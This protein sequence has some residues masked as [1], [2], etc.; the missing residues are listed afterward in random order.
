MQ[1]GSGTVAH[2]YMEPKT[3]HVLGGLSHF[4]QI[5]IETTEL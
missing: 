4:I 1:Y 5:R 3:S 2:V